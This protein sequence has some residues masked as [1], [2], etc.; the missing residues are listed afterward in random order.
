MGEKID[1]G[2]SD[3][4]RKDI[5]AMLAAALAGSYTLYVKTHGFHWNVRGADFS[6]LH[7]LFEGQYQE[8]AAAVDEI[9]ERIRALGQDAPGSFA[10]FAK[11]SPIK[12]QTKVPAA[13]AMV[14]ELMRDHETLARAFRKIA[15]R[16][17]EAGDEATN[18]L[19]GE[20][21]AAHEKTAWMLR[22]TI[23]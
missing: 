15:A 5:A 18:G 22:A 4:E 10:Q 21:I 2:I 23:G 16:A 7:A 14:K 19:A 9:A 6:A 20:R 17:A 11:L 12:E 13:A 8:L 3:N 1:T